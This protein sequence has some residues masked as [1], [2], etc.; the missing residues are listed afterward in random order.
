MTIHLPGS[1]QRICHVEYVKE[2]GDGVT[3]ETSLLLHE[4][5]EAGGS[6]PTSDPIPYISCS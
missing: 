6:G 5:G 4:T 1:I 2:T 3:E